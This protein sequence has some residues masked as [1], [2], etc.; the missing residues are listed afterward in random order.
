MIPSKTTIPVLTAPFF[1]P[2]S[3]RVDLDLPTGLSIAQ[4]VALALPHASEPDLAHARIVLVSDRG[5]VVVDRQHWK[6][7]YPHAGVRVVIRI[8]PSNGALRS[9][10][11]VV[12]SIAAIALGQV[13]AV[14]LSQTLGISTQL[15]AGLIGLGVTVL[16]N[17]LINALI[18][19][20]STDDDKKTS[21][22]IS[23]WRNKLDPDGVVPLIMG[24]V[25]YAP[26]FAATSHTEI[27]G[28]LQ[29]IRALFYFGYGPLSFSDFRIGETSFSD[30]DEIQTE[31]REGLPTDAPLTLYPTQIYEESVGTE[32]VRPEHRDDEGN[33]IDGPGIETPIIRTT[34]ADASGASIIFGFPAG[35]GK[36]DDKGKQRSVTVSMR[37]RQRPAGTDAWTEVVT[38]DFTAK[39]FE[40]FY[41]QYTWNFATRGRYD[42]EVTRMTDEFTNQSTQGRTTWV[43]L[44]TLRPEYPL[45][46]TSPLALVAVRVKATYQLNGALDNFNALASRRCL[47]W[48]SG[49]QTWIQRETSNPASLYRHVLQSAANPKPS[50]DDELNL[51]LL[52]DWHEFCTAKGLKYDKA[53]DD[54]GTLGDR[55][56][57]I[58][59]A[60][61][62]TR[63]HDGIR[64]GV[65]I[66]RPQDLVVDHINPRVSWNFQ[67]TRTYFEAPHGFRVQFLDATNDYKQAERLVPWPGY[68]GDILL[69]EQLELPGKTDPAEI[70]REARRKM[71]EAI[72]RP[73]V[74]TATVDGPIRVA[75]RGDLVM[76]SFDVLDRTQLATRIKSVDGKLVVLEDAVTMIAGR[77]YA[78]RFRVFADETDTVGTSLVRRVRTYA[79]THTLLTLSGDGVSPGV[80]DLLHFGEALTESMPLIVTRVEAAQDMSSIFTMID[81]SPIIDELTDAEV[82]PPWSGRVGDDIGN[83]TGLPPAPV[84]ASIETGLSGTDT[85][86]GLIVNLR[87]GTGT[88]PSVTFRVQHR[89]AGATIWQT[90]DFPAS[91]GGCSITGYTTGQPVQIRA[92]ALNAA[93]QVGPFTIVVNVTIGSQDAAV[94]QA[95]DSGAVTVGALLGGATVMFSTGV[96]TATM[97]VQIYRSLTS[98]V[99]RSTDAV[100]APISV[101]PSRG[102]SAAVGDTTRSNKVTNGG[103][104][105]DSAWTKG[106]GWAIASGVASH[107]AG[108]AASLSQAQAV[109]E[110]VYYRFAFTLSGVTAGSLTPQFTGGTTNAGTARTANGNFSDRV[111]AISGNDTLAFAGTSAFVG[112]IDDIVLFEET[113]T[114]LA[115]GIHY[116][117]LEPQNTDG[118]PGPM[119]GPFTVTIR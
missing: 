45:N 94:P 71:Y 115:A 17:L 18:P 67:S 53:M 43:A 2:G 70:W 108:S 111:Q 112:S 96:D 103:F 110:G 28:D 21:Y 61:R 57:E 6:R 102:Y 83:D 95:L 97:Q 19:P 65:V 31:I 119:A 92:A 72:Y 117:W 56:K 82:P 35:L 33:E 4:I 69:T 38:L 10:L 81:A 22:Q 64:Y 40:G 79:G 88:V 47:D 15:A 113:S 26:P 106:T 89:L 5:S 25:R 116:F 105:A 3:A 114:C 48:D 101:Q 66:D 93:A 63:W 29:Y 13:W 52:Q 37:I 14:P 16:G 41:R 36:V 84:F 90:V 104:D 91:N 23:G 20:V 50:T 86:G 34:G 76:G 59:A 51:A 55:L 99:S 62:A 24:K 118:V 1:D 32:L 60:G 68:S 109:T 27:V 44:Q 7:V 54:D 8:V 77:D 12:V 30:Y 75:T 58:A 80:G 9:I 107:V 98:S 11:S 46:F 87:P 42:I 49:S 100:G 78:M 85:E 74:Y 73:D 39:K